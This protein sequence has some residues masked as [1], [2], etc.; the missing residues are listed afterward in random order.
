VLKVLFVSAVTIYAD[1][2]V[3]L[4]VTFRKAVSM[5]AGRQCSKRCLLTSIISCFLLLALRL[6]VPFS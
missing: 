6:S 1:R 5:I 2:S 3:F 4:G